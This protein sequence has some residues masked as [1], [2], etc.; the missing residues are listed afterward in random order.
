MSSDMVTKE[1]TIKYTE[2]L[3]ANV[4]EMLT[5]QPGPEVVAVLTKTQRSLVERGNKIKVGQKCSIIKIQM[6]VF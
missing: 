5:K 6:N 2:K 1:K 4:R 3:Y